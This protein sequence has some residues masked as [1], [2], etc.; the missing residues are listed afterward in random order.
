MSDAHRF[1][2]VIA[3]SVANR[4]VESFQTEI[5]ITVTNRKRSRQSC[6]EESLK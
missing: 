3:H 5:H 2:E 1:I 6:F 4:N